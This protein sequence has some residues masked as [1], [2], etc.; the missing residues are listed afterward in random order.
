M[1]GT[2]ALDKYDDFG[3]WLANIR[4]LKDP[5]TTPAGFVPATQY[6]ALDEQEHLVGMTNLRHHLN[7]YL[8]AYGGHIGYSVRPSDAEERLRQPD[9]PSDPRKGPGTR[10]LQGAHLLRPL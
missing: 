1:D 5:A 9:A 8:L 10:H 6:L 3:Q 4:R 7:D 2:S